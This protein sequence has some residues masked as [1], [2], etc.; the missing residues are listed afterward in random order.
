M[1]LNAVFVATHETQ[2]ADGFA[3]FVHTV[4]MDLTSGNATQNDLPQTVLNLVSL[5]VCFITPPM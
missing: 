5:Q 2:K 1:K 3:P 4:H